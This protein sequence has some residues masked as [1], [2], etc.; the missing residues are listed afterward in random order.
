MDTMTTNEGSSEICST[1][2]SSSTDSFLPENSPSVENTQFE[3]WKNK[4]NELENTIKQQSSQI[5]QV[6]EKN[7]ESLVMIQES[8]QIVKN[9]RKE[10]SKISGDVKKHTKENIELLG[11]F[12]ALFTFISVSSSVALQIKGIYHAAF[13]ISVFCLC[14]FSFLHFLHSL[15]QENEGYVWKKVW[16]VFCGLLVLITIG[17]GWLCW[18]FENAS[19]PIRNDSKEE[20]AQ[21]SQANNMIINSEK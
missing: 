21:G 2:S 15:L 13:F 18:N 3:F 14:L 10:V 11:I 1:T 17:L 7:A 4:L 16:C 9:L 8:E 20:F 12:V 19:L 5:E 6:N